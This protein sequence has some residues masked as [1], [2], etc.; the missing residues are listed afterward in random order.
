MSWLTHIHELVPPY[1][2]HIYGWNDSCAL[3]AG[4]VLLPCTYWVP[5]MH[6]DGQNQQDI[7]VNDG[8]M[9]V[10]LFQDLI[11]EFL[12]PPKFLASCFY[13]DNMT[14]TGQHDKGATI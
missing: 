4:G 8:K 14:T 13:C 3:G 5:P 9:A 6:W 7:T 2:P 11:S 1:L 12:A 10:S